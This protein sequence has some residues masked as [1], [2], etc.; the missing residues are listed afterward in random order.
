MIPVS[1]RIGTGSES[2]CVHPCLSTFL[3]A[4]DSFADPNVGDCS[5]VCI[6]TPIRQGISRDARRWENGYRTVP[7]PV[8]RHS[9]ASNVSGQTPVPFL[10]GFD[11]LNNRLHSTQT[12]RST[13]P[14]GPD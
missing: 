1:L 14:V 3:S 8:Q 13:A 5:A 11:R 12:R 9:A 7:G 4:A 10:C 2:I 6:L